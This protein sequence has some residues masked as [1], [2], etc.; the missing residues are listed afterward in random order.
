MITMIDEIFDRQYQDG[1]AEL[2]ATITD[3]FARFGNAVSNAFAVLYRIEYS[4]PWTIKRRRTRARI[5]H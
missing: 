3:A 5:T 1:R 2:N 4:E